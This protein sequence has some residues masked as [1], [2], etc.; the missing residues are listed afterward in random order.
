MAFPRSPV[1]SPHLR[2]SC[3]GE[4]YQLPSLVAPVTA[5]W[6]TFGAAR[7]LSSAAAIARRCALLRQPV[8]QALQFRLH[9]RVCAQRVEAGGQPGHRLYRRRPFECIDRRVGRRRSHVD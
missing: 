7:A 9:Y 8:A 4:H 1:T 3:R 6:P 5:P 2:R